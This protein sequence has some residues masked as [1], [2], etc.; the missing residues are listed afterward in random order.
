MFLLVYVFVCVL[1]HVTGSAWL[2]QTQCSLIRRRLACVTLNKSRIWLRPRH[3]GS[4][5]NKS[6]FVLKRSHVGTIAPHR[7]RR[8]SCIQQPPSHTYKTRPPRSPQR[9]ETLIS[10]AL[11]SAACEG[12]CGFSAPDH[13]FLPPGVGFQLLKESF[14]LY[15]TRDGA[16][17]DPGDQK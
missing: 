5:V 7:P 15:Q 3:G 6:T 10:L 12:T 1:F 9:S 11:T 14:S 4:S 13:H 2:R 17:G 16:K 8:A